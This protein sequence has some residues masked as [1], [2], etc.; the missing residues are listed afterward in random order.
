[1][2]AGVRL[3]YSAS[4]ICFVACGAKGFGHWICETDRGRP[5]GMSVER[6]RDSRRDDDEECLLECLSLEDLEDE[7]LEDE[8]LE[9]DLVDFSEGTSRMF[10]TRPVVGSVV[11]AWAGSWETW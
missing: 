1:M 3:P 11:E 6:A 4:N 5:L 10:N 8:D 2:D 9:D 7:D